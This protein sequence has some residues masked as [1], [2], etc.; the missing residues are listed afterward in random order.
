M[1]IL[2]AFAFKHPDIGYCQ[3]MNYVAAA[4]IVLHNTPGKGQVVASAGL[5][6]DTGW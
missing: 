3:G 6:P 5:R 2:K 1:G 4:L